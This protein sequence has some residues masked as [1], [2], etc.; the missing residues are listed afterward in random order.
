MHLSPRVRVPALVLSGLIV[1]GA[2]EPAIGLGDGTRT[3]G[4]ALTQTISAP[5]TTGIGDPYFPKDGNGGYDVRSYSID[6]RYRPATGALIGTTRVRLTAKRRLERLNLDLLLRA[7][8]VWVRGDRTRFSQGTHELTVRPRPA[9]RKG[10]TVNVTVAYGGRPAG[11]SFNGESP[12]ERTPTGGIAVGEPHIAAWWFPSNDHPS[13]KARFSI[14]L[15]VPPR[16]EAISNGRLLSRRVVGDTRAWRWAPDKPMT[17]YLAFAAFGQYRLE[18]GHTAV[19]PYLYAFE[20]RLGRQATAAKRSVRRTA[21]VTRWLERRFGSYPYADIGG[22][23]TAAR[24]GY[25]LENQTRP[26]YGRDMFAYGA[27][28]SLIV[29]EMAHQWFG[30]KVAVQR[31][32]HIWLNEGLATYAEWL[33]HDHR[34]GP[35]PQRRLMRIYNVFGPGSG[36]WRLPIGDPGRDRIFDYAVYER[37]AMTTQ[38][39]RNRVGTRVFFRILRTW[40][41]DN[42][43][44]LG[45]TAEFKRLAERRSGEKLDGFFRAWLFSGKKPARTEA[46]GL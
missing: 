35:S 33:W 1:A 9:I 30:D 26:V 17:T 34:G 38:A 12:F 36:Y 20:N 21:E 25:A 32:R 15:R 11:L 45:S 43:D 27:T 42:R 24:L 13:D 41:H 37:G 23:V 28:S 19:G 3:A 22:V 16:M 8:R 4:G 40:V 18:R 6:V 44:G 5:S 46:N 31:W 10:R 2:V 29:H 7:S 14:R 39:L